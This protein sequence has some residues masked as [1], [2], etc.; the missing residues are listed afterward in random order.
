MSV[1]RV[2]PTSRGSSHDN[3]YSA[4]RPRRPCEV[5][6]FD[7]GGGE[8]QVAETGQDETDARPPGR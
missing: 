8:A 6:S 3:P 4:G 7:P 1:A 2:T 5:V